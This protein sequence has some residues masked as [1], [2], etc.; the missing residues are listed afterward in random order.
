MLTI[1][2][3]E[4]CSAHHAAGTRRTPVSVALIGTAHTLM[5]DYRVVVEVE[6]EGDALVEGRL[7][8]ERVVH[9]VRLV[10]DEDAVRVV[11]G[12]VN[13]AVADRLGGDRLHVLR[14]VERKL[15][16]NVA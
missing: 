3:C 14:V 12:R 2:P 1:M 5:T 8:L 9:V 6:A 11:H 16:G 7:R 4:A 13:H 15:R 10:R